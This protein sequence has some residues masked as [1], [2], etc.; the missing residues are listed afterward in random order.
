MSMNN[1]I[2][3]GYPIENGGDHMAEMYAKLIIEGKRTFSEVPDE[4][5][6]ETRQILIAMGGEDLLEE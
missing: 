2:K 5:K 3:T 6:E 4:I 1:S